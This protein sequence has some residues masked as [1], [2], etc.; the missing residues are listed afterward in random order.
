MR[1]KKQLTKTDCV[2]CQVWLEA[3]ETV[4]G[5]NITVQRD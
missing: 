4:D 3:K 5:L 2:L 1:P